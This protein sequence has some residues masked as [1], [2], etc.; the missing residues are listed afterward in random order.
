MCRTP[1]RTSATATTT[2]TSTTRALPRYHHHR[3][4]PTARPRL[5][6]KPNSRP[7]PHVPPTPRRAAQIPAGS[8]GFPTQLNVRYAMFQDT[9]IMMLVGFGFLYTLLRRYAWSGVSYNY[10]ITVFTIEWAVLALGFWVNATKHRVAR[11]AGEPGMFSAV[12]LGIDSLIDADYIA[13]TVLI[14]FGAIIGRVSPMQCLVR[15]GCG[16]PC[17]ARAPCPTRAPPRNP[18]R[19]RPPARARARARSSASSARSRARL[20]C[21][22]GPLT[23]RPCPPAARPVCTHARR[24]QI[25]LFFEV[26]FATANVQIGRELRVT[27]PGGSMVRARACVCVPVRAR[28][29]CEPPRRG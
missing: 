1:R 9:H 10:L 27:D 6:P 13:A 11:E 8:D 20:A 21:S 7:P 25:M 12:P 5:G 24:V 22:C 26:I 17:P 16:A 23:A 3:Q 15:G 19:P 4:Q 18:P 14:S 29:R 2:A 28:A